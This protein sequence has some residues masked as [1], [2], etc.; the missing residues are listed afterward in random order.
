[1]SI[2]LLVRLGRCRTWLWLALLAAAV[3]FLYA[4]HP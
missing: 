2:I 1:M 4:A 3:A